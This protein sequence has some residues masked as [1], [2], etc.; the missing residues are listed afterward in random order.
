MPFSKKILKGIDTPTKQEP[1]ST[2]IDLKLLTSNID[3][4]TK[5]L[6][7]FTN[8]KQLSQRKSKGKSQSRVEKKKMLGLKK[9]F[10]GIS[11]IK[12]K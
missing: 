4:M 5:K 12:K 2:T 7:H 8:I 9:Q 1:N 6:T 3:V 10:E 11:A